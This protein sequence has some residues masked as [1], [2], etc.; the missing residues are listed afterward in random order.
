MER[1]LSPQPQDDDQPTSGNV[2]SHQDAERILQSL[3]TIV[4][5]LDSEYR[6][7]RWNHSAAEKFNIAAHD[8]EGKRFFDLPVQWQE[9]ERLKALFDEASKE[10]PVQSEIGF[11][12]GAQQLT[13]GVKIYSLF[14][15]D[16]SMGWL[17]QGADITHQKMLRFQLDQAQ[18]MEAVGQLAAGVA[19]EINTP[20]QYIGD[21]VRFVSKSLKKLDAILELLPDLMENSDDDWQDRIEEISDELPTARKVRK[22]LTQIPEALDDAM[23][24]VQ[25]VAKIV[26]AMKAF[27]HPGSDEKG[28]LNLNEVLESTV[29]VARN[30]WKYVSKLEMDLDPELPSIQGFHGELNQAFLNIVV[31]AAHAIGDR[32]KRGDFE[33]GLIHIST[34]TRDGGVEVCIRDTGGG[35]PE[36]V[37]NRVYEPF[38]TTKEVG[39]GTGQGLAIAYNVIVEKHAGKLWFEIAEGEGT[40]FHIFLPL[41]VEETDEGDFS[42]TT[43]QPTED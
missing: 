12:D 17:L 25:K 30:E 29:T 9:P 3:Q 1:N 34:K 31:N 2:G 35:I 5:S 27:S 8:A 10:T 32:V 40:T 7:Q 37:R 42:K 26:A 28:T 11:Q 20:I 41:L 33:A 24:G 39:K 4:V 13:L 23:T 38:F 43:I 18:K 36:S 22:A 21:S 14:D 15:E 16:Q 6:V 19:H